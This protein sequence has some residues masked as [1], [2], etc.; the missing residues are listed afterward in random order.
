[1]AKV[2]SELIEHSEEHNALEYFIKPVLC[3]CDICVTVYLNLIKFYKLK[4]SSLLP[5][6][7]VATAKFP[8][9]M[10]YA[11]NQNYQLGNTLLQPVTNKRR[12]FVL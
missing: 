12:R 7:K 8:Q 10:P 2:Q 4:S 9:M 5:F 6:Y 11:R 1:M 3:T